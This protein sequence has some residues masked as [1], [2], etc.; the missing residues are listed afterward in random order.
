M[1]NI[2]LLPRRAERSGAQAT[3]AGPVLGGL[4]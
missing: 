4:D 3:F 1:A 2:N